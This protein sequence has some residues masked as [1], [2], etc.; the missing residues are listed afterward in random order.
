MT[1]WFVAFGCVLACLLPRSVASETPPV[2]AGTW[3]V[4][5]RLPNGALKEQWLIQQKGATIAGTARGARGELPVSGTI[6]G[7]S[8]RVTVTDKD[9]T[10][11]VRAMVDGNAMDGTVTY[12]AGEQYMW[13]AKRST[14]K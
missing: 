8:F 13:Q 12:P 14:I 9:K 6:A 5:T 10:Y 3:E 11:R 7:A 2:L 4:T 1:R